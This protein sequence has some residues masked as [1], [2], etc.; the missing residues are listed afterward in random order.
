MLRNA[1]EGGP[2]VRFQ[3]ARSLSGTGLETICTILAKNQELF[4]LFH[5]NLSDFELRDNEWL[6][7]GQDNIPAGATKSVVV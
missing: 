2:T 3:R 5:E 7:W 6:Y 4:C 1:D